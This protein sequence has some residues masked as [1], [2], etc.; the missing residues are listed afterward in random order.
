MSLLRQAH[1]SSRPQAV[2]P[3][4]KGAPRSGGDC[5]AGTASPWNL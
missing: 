5:L 4:W 3:L 1:P 2:W